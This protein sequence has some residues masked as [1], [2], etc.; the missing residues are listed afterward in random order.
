[1]RYQGCHDRG[2]CY[3]PQ[4]T[5]FTY[6]P[7][8]F[9]E[10]DS[11]TDEK[12]VLPE[13]TDTSSINEQAADN[14]FSMQALL[15]NVLLAFAGGLLL[16]LMPCV[17][18]V[19]AMKAMTFVNS[20]GHEAKENILHSWAYTAG[21]VV[22]FIIVGGGLLLL[23]NITGMDLSWG[24]QMSNSY[25]L[26]FLIGVF[27]FLG[28]MLFGY[29]VVGTS[30]MGVGSGLASKGGLKGSFFT[31]ALATLVGAPCTGP[32]MGAPLFFALT[33]P[34]YIG[35]AVFVALGIGMAL[36]MLIIAYIPAVGRLLPRP[37]AWME[38]FKQGMSFP[39]FAAALC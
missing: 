34:G 12:P 36:P 9:S 2:L 14:A 30:L 23:K 32:F 18:P 25:V 31:G 16:N 33:S 24:Q 6:Y 35:L 38:V 39:M 21:A 37:G 17:F 20:S 15:I 26:I 22:F 7:T 5:S 1:M 13:Q 29:T 3:P 19:L 27:F 4:R 28:L 10:G 11:T 8:G